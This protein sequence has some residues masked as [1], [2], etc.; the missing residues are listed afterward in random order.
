MSTE[1][2]RK[3][4][5]RFH[6]EALLAANYHMAPRR[7]VIASE[8]IR[9]PVL[10]RLLPSVLFLRVVSIFDE[11]LEFYIDDRSIQ[12]PPDKERNLNNRINVLDDNR[13]LRDS[14][15]CHCIRERRNELAHEPDKFVQWSELYKCLDVVELELKN[16]GLL[17][18]RPKYAWF[19]S[20]TPFTDHSGEKLVTYSYGLKAIGGQTVMDA[21]WIGTDPIPG[22]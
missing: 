14:A 4:W 1:D 21:T 6:Q 9:N 19:A 8:K 17:G 5:E 18:D 13:I 11:A 12:W 10:D 22:G 15:T 20:V 7:T 16:L 2:I 3:S